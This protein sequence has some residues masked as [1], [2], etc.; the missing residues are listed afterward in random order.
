MILYNFFNQMK[1]IPHYFK[2]VFLID[3]SVHIIWFHPINLRWSLFSIMLIFCLFAP[4]NIFALKK[5]VRK[6]LAIHILF[7]LSIY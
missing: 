2:T 6:N 1:E 3:L 5:I 7:L 4:K